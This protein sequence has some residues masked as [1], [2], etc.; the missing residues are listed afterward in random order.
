[1]FHQPDQ[2]ATLA[3]LHHIGKLARQEGVTREQLT[4]IFIPVIRPW[5]AS[6]LHDSPHSFPLVRMAQAPEAVARSLTD[7]AASERMLKRLGK[8]ERLI[9]GAGACVSMVRANVVHPPA[10]SVER[11][12]GQA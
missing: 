11:P 2:P 8:N 3:T 4:R 5:N 12:V 6:V 7:E 10:R 1:M 9:M